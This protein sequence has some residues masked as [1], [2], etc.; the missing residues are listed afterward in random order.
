MPNIGIIASSISA[1]LNASSYESIATATVGAGG[2]ASVTFSSIPST[3]K[4]LQIRVFASDTSSGATWGFC[5]IK[6]NNL[7]TNYG[8]RH[9]VYGT[10]AATGA[11]AASATY[12]MTYV[13][14]NGYFS[15][16][17]V[18]ILD[19]TDTNKNKTV[20]YISGNDQN[21]GGLV[22]LGSGL[23]MNTVA[24]NQIDLTAGVLFTQYSKFALYGIKG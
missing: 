16:G 1:S 24:I 2:V 5:N 15:T 4:H 6:F 20:R 8:Y 21:G 10:G 11:S 12:P 19:Y 23:W 9:D 13:G 22:S 7:G 3:Y 17:I 14:N 18:D